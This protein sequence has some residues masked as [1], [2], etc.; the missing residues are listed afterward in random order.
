MSKYV[1]HGSAKKIDGSLLPKKSTDLGNRQENLHTAVYAATNREVAIAMAIL[2]TGDISGSSLNN[3]EPYGIYYSGSPNANALVYLY[4][5]HKDK[6]EQ[7]ANPRQYISRV[8]IEP[9]KVFKIKVN[10]YLHLVRK[11]TLEETKRFQKL[12]DEKHNKN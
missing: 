3:E 7:T 10:E 11:A 9:S 4:V 2:R 6:F 8:P 5:F 1:Y 12:I